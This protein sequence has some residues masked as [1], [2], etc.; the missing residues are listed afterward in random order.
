MTPD[1]V[2][3]D[4]TKRLAADGGVPSD[5][6]RDIDTFFSR[7]VPALGE[8]GMFGLLIPA[9]FGGSGYDVTQYVAALET[10]GRHDMMAAYSVNEHSTIGSLPLV[11]S[12]TADQRSQLLPEMAAGRTLAAFCLT[13]PASGS[14]VRTLAT[15]AEPD[16]DGFRIDGKKIHISL[17][18]H[19]GMFT[20]L[21]EV[22]GPSRREKTAF[23]VPADAPGLSLGP[24]NS[25]P[26]GY[27]IPVAGS[28][29][30]ESCH[31]GRDQVLGEVGRGGGIFRSALEIARVG[32]TAAYVGGASDALDRCLEHVQTRRSFGQ[33]LAEHQL[34]QAKLADMSID[35][36]AARLLV[37]HAAQMLDTAPEHATAASARAKVFAIEAAQRVGDQAVQLF[38]GKAFLDQPPVDWYLRDAKMGAILGGTSEIM[39]LLIAKDLLKSRQPAA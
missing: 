11:Q 38:G 4:V 36:E 24:E 32:L 13:E 1:E 22:P 29:V 17:A 23:L 6:G 19:A 21:A 34:V 14:D 9:E 18:H 2:I 7:T 27:L 31:A 20:V 5:H 3:D 28:V 16:G 25:S 37:R 15:T 35:I 10:L 8:R 30:L 12:G 33:S 39:R 26:P